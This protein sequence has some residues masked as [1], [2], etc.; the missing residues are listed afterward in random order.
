M[1]RKIL[2]Y[3]I[4][5]LVSFSTMAEHAIVKNADLHTA[6]KAFDRAYATNDVELYFSLYADDAIV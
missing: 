3:L 1:M 5:F 4:I 2:F 6:I